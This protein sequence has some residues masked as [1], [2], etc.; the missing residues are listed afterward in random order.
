MLLG[1]ALA[2]VAPFTQASPP[3]SAQSR[4]DIELAEA[5]VLAG[6]GH[7]SLAVETYD[8]VL[9]IDPEQ[10]EALTDGGWL[11][12]LAGVSSS[13]PSLVGEGDREI[14]AAAALDPGYAL[15]HGYEGV[16]LLEDNH[17]PRAAVATF[18]VMLAD[19]PAVS[20]VA[21][22][23]PEAAKAYAR[24]PRAAAVSLRP[25]KSLPAGLAATSAAAAER[26]EAPCASS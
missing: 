1:L 8:K 15:A 11:V 24:R 14:A 13:R 18:R 6:H 20:L 17:D 2:G 5:A 21:S 23:R 19:H 3:L 4:I 26:E 25:V 16:A 10:K 12:R 22:L 7:L 9:T